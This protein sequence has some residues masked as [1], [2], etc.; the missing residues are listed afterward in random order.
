MITLYKLN[1]ENVYL[2]DYNVFQQYHSALT[3]STNASGV[4]DRVQLSV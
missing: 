4:K 3:K 1:Q 2:R